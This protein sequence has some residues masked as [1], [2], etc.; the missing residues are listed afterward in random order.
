[1]RSEWTQES[2]VEHA[3]DVLRNENTYVF[4]IPLVHVLMKQ[5][6]TESYQG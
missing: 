3:K 1:M 4:V 5:N 6:K 2:I